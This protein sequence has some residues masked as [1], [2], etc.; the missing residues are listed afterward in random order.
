VR[1]AEAPDWL[2]HWLRTGKVSSKANLNTKQSGGTVLKVRGDDLA[3]A[4]GAKQGHRHAEA[5][6]L[7]GLHLS[8]G[9]SSDHV[10]QLALEFGERCRPP[11]ERA[12]VERI[13]SDLATKERA[14]ALLADSSDDDV[15]TVPLPEPPPW[16]TLHEDA[17]HG[18]AGDIVNTIEPATESDP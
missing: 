18:L 11:M 5:T 14:A 15:D 6:R 4:G 9:E 2:L 17:L 8:R 13:V 10:L 1:L 3:L 7:I 12:E 16:P